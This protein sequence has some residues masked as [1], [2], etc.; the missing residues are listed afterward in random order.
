MSR[1][2]VVLTGALVRIYINGK[3]YNES[4]SVEYSIDYG[5]NE[6]YGIDSPFPQEISSTRA[7][8]A[9]SIRGV[10]IRNSGGIQAYNARSSI[11]DIVKSQYISIRIQDRASGEDLLYVPNAKISRQSVSA[12]TKSVVSLSFQFKGMVAFESL[13][14]S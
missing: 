3:I 11:S 12:T 13:D 10:R 4:Q 1:P 8:V 9:G 7:M 2:S 14:R 5:E 6:I